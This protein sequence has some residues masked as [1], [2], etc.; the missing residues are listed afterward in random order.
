M[1]RHSLSTSSQ[2]TY[3][4][5][6]AFSGSFDPITLGHISL[7]KRILP[8]F[9]N[10]HIVVA[11]GGD[12]EPLFNLDERYV[13]VQ[14]SLKDVELL[15]DRIKITRWE[16]LLV[17]YCQT[18][19][20]PSILRGLRNTNDL[21]FEKIMATI[22]HQLNE[23]IETIFLLANPSYRDI[24]STAIKEL[25]RVCTKPQQLKKFLTKSVIE[26]FQKKELTL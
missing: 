13:L 5:D 11:S 3:N 20:I 12:K 7:I 21:Q 4:R 17:D 6:I 19:N 18:H 25:A 24:S 10:I 15:S 1:D 26:A 2:M 23:R 16:G 8:R 9:E 14:Q 22:N